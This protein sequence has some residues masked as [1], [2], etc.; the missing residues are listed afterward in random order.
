MGE[1]VI[2]ASIVVLGAA[3]IL[4]TIRSIRRDGH[5]PRPHDPDYDTR[6]P[7]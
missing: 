3:G 5:R 1:W 4:G 6:R 2:A 7:S